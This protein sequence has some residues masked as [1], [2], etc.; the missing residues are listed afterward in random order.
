MAATLEPRF[1][2]Y[3][4]K[5]LA[6]PDFD[7][8]FQAV[9]GVGMLEIS[10]AAPALVP[11]FDD[12]E[13]RRDAL[14]AYALSAPCPPNR[15]E[16]RRLYERIGR[17]ADLNEDEAVEVKEAVNLR[18]ARHELE[19]LFDSDGELIED[20]PVNKTQKVGRNDPCLCG[21]GKKYKKCCGA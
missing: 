11:L 8:R 14:H 17:L 15:R 19:P 7:I 16:M 1:A 4:P 5:H 13:L 3:F 18:L 20:P 12:Q 6:D 21:S 9:Q 10:Q 2:A